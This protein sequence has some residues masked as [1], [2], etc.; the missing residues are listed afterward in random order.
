[1]TTP[2]PISSVPTGLLNLSILN[3][4]DAWKTAID[5]VDYP[6][7][8]RE[9]FFKDGDEFENAVGKTN[10]GRDTVFYGVIV[11]RDRVGEWSTISTVTGMYG[12]LLTKNIY[13]DLKNDLN[14][15]PHTLQDVYVSG[16]GGNHQLRIR[17]DDKKSVCGRDVEMVLTLKTSVDGT[18][19]HVVRLSAWDIKNKVELLGIN[20][21][22]LGVSTRHTTT[23]ADRH[24]A[25]STVINSLIKEWSETVI[26]LMELMGDTEFDTAFALDF[27]ENMM[28]ESGFSKT[29]INRACEE[30]TMTGKTSALDVVTDLSKFCNTTFE[31]K[32]E[33]LEFFREKL[34]K[35]VKKVFDTFRKTIV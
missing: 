32:Q 15:I 9:L 13:E 24:V 22:T 1:M 18:S 3:V 10:T 8:L 17:L 21:S 12:T 29:H 2:N 19:K 34:N 31:N 4:D 16:S 28:E 23:I 20:G 11:D 5:C 33:R 14:D 7:S 6:V 26:P 25:F 27:L 35:N 30:I